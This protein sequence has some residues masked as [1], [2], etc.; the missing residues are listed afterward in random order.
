MHKTIA[1]ICSATALLAA[2]ATAPA[3]AQQAP[4]STLSESSAP[5]PA[6]AERAGTRAGSTT[7]SSGTV[8]P[9]STTAS[10]TI[11]DEKLRQFV[12]SAQEVA[13]LTDQ[14]SAQYQSAQDDG[15]KQRIVD[16]ANERMAAAV[17][18][19]G[20]TV[21]EFNGI[22]QAVESDPTLAQRARQ[23]MQ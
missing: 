14:Y 2:S 21:E 7:P 3:I 5:S 16:E 15:A 12:T 9:A 19:N 6:A 22:G 10:P 17:E 23:L 18:A 8:A 20:L 4:T 1:A 11:S 13:A